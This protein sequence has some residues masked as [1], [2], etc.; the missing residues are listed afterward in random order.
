MK[1]WMILL[2]VGLC[3][4]ATNAWAVRPQTVVHT[5]E[6]DFAS[7]EADNVV[8]WSLGEVTLGAKARTLVDKHVGMD[9]VSAVAVGSDGRVYVGTAAR[10]V[11]LRIG[12][13]DKAVTLADLPG[14]MVTDLIVEGDSLW[15][16]TAG[17][18]AGVYRIDLTAATTPVQAE[19]F[20]SDADAAGVWAIGRSGQTLYAATSPKGKLF[21]IDADGAGEAVFTAKQKTLRSLL[22]AGEAAYVGA[23]ADGLVYR[24]DLAGGKHASRVLLDA[25]ET[26]IVALAADEAGNVYAAGTNVTSGEPAEPAETDG[27]KPAP[28]TDGAPAPTTQPAAQ[29]PKQYVVQAGDT[30]AGI[31]RKVYGE[32]ADPKSIL[33][34]NPGLDPAALEPGTKLTV[35]TDASKAAPDKKAKPA[36]AASP[37]ASKKSSTKMSSGR[38]SGRKPGRAKGGNSIYRIDAD[39]FVKVVGKVPQTVFDMAY[40]AAGTPRLLLA[41]AGGQVRQIVLATGAAGAMATVDPKQVTALAIS[42]SGAIIV[43]TTESAQVIEIADSPAATGTLVSEPIDAEQIARW[44]SISIDGQTPAGTAVTVATRTGNVAEAT[45]ATWT[46]WSAEIPVTASWAALTSP[47]GRFLQYRLTLTR[48]P[49]AAAAGAVGLVDGVKVVYQVGNLPPEIEAVMV[50]PASQPDKRSAL[51]KAP[52]GPMRYRI[53]AIKAEDPNEDH[54]RFDLSYRTRPDGLWIRW[55][56][57]L[58]APQAAWDTQTVPDGVYEVKVLAT[59]APGNSPETAMTDERLTRTI[60]VDNTAPRIVDIGAAV[61]GATVTVTGRLNDDNR[62]AGARYQLDSQEVAVVMTA[63]DGV[64]DSP[65][66][67][68]KAVVADLEPGAHVITVA[69]VDEFGNV[70][71]TAVRVVIGR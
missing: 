15:A 10:G 4:A 25:Q 68:I 65:D 27:G 34:A 70:A 51:T 59:D 17:G 9:A 38:A 50:A 63:T 39:G 47:V 18:E 40:A 30:L 1:R 44:S 31:A 8:V 61:D 56:K 7:G 41:T 67:R 54:L 60:I 5:S 2:A 45:E 42:E 28:R 52:D 19:R 71:R 58:T 11:I 13:D 48:D 36:E 16:A 22:I 23:G 14:V 64:Y 20:W 66:E 37:E 24:I 21:A 26:E 62:I 57:D 53:V 6:A 32:G 33:K 29:G 49:K 12:S 55:A 43:G 35:P 46:D 3:W 69:A